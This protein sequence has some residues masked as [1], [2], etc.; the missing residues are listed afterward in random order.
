MSKK[1]FHKGSNFELWL[2][3]LFIGS[4]IVAILLVAL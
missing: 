2:A 1:D 3:T 4:A